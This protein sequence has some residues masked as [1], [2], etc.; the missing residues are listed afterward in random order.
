MRNN[1]LTAERGVDAASLIRRAA[2]HFPEVTAVDDGARAL[3]FAEAVDSLWQ[4]VD[5]K[6]G[7]VLEI[8]VHGFPPARFECVA[9]IGEG[10]VFWKAA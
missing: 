7:D 9:E 10:K 4:H 3:T 2:F 8:G 6:R 5:V 1:S